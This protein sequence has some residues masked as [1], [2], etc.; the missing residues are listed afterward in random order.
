[1]D[2][3]PTLPP[4]ALSAL[5]DVLGPGGLVLD[6][7]VVAAHS[8]DWTGRYRGRAPALLRPAS[9]TEVS[10]VLEV[11][12]DHGL[13]VVPQGGNTG[14]VGGS[15]PLG[16]ELVLSLRRL[17]AIGPVDRLTAQVTVGAG[18]TLADLQR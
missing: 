12:R 6:A 2:T 18:V 7:D 17:D 8:T 13:A 14:L 15:V 5:R 9:T 10:A 1:M 11:C 3:A 4:A 16:G